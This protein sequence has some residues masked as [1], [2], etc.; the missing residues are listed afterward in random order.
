M[1]RTL[2]AVYRL[3]G[4][5]LTDTTQQTTVAVLRSAQATIDVA[6]WVSIDHVAGYW[7]S[8]GLAERDN[9]AAC[10]MCHT[11]TDQLQLQNTV[12]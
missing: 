3:N 5:V 8:A 10:V 4:Y 7:T 6:M 11:V 12:G 1:Q 2:G 9:D